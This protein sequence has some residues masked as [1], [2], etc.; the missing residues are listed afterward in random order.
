MSNG[1]TVDR[2][3][4]GDRTE[5]GALRQPGLVDPVAGQAQREL[6]AVDRQ[7]I[8]AQ[9]ADPVVVAQEVL[10]GTDVVLVAVRQHERLDALGVLAQIGEVGQDQV[11]PVH[12]RVGKHQ[13]AVDEDDRAVGV[14]DGAL[15]DG[16]AVAA[17]L[18]EPTEE[19][20][21]DRRCRAASAIGPRG[22][23]CA[24]SHVQ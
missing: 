23:T 22:S 1:P 10:D 16:H 6:G 5:V 19:H 13:P 9:V 3:A 2:L 7:R 18:A 4:V 14:V 20:D 15:L 12:V 8:V 17:D 21:P 11:D 24:V